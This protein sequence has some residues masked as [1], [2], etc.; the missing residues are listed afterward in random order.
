M[1]VEGIVAPILSGVLTGSGAA[2]LAKAYINKSLEKIEML[3][4]KIDKIEIQLSAIGVKLDMQNEDHKLVA[5]HE[6]QL[7]VLENDRRKLSKVKG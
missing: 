1:S 2:W 5:K 4:S 3:D 6:L 7:A